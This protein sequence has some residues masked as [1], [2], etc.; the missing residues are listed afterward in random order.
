[1]V[2]VVD[3]KDFAGV[4]SE[5]SNTDR[6]ALIVCSGD[7]GEGKS[8]ITS[9]LLKETSK[10]NKTEFTYS[11]SLTYS[12]KELKNWI[13]G[14]KEGNHQ[15]PERSC[16]L[17]DELI[18]MF[19]KRNWYEGGQI[20]GIELL[21]KCRDRHLIVAGNIPDFME[22]DS[23]LLKICTFWIHVHERGRAWVFQKDRNPFVA[24]K[25]HISENAK[26]YVKEGN[27]YRCKGFICEIHFNDWTPKEKE[28]YYL[29][30][31]DKR[32][33]TEGQRD[34]EERYRD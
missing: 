24:D 15:K 17:A 7:M 23:S 21:N 12:R 9:Q 2:Q 31:N 32:K 29:V 34:R 10:Y 20:D 30:R 5:I 14:D 19:F 8:C 16:I 22:L 28:E 26:I 27:P 1:M 13:D 6:W 3:L 11:D 33:N 4:I 18:S 25:W